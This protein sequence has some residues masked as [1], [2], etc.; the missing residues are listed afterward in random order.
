ETWAWGVVCKSPKCS[1]LKPAES[2]TVVFISSI[3][4]DGHHCHWVKDCVGKNSQK[5][6][7]LF[8]MY[9][10]LISLHVLIMVG[11]HFPHY[12][13]EDWIKQPTAVILFILMCFE[14]LHLFMFISVMPETQVLFI[15]MDKIGIEKLK[16]G[17][18]MG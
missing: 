18:K 6:F 9:T 4:E 7:S 14:G 5:Y 12:C 13:E 3:S 8:T 10:A 1:S 15:C 16:K 2:I 11:F 17:E